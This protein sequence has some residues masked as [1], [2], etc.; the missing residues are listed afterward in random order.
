MLSGTAAL[1]QAGGGEAVSAL[2]SE[3][4]ALDRNRDGLISKVEALG[5]S[6]IQ[7]RF[8]VFDRDKDGL[9]SDAEY[10]RAVEDNNR[11][12]LHDSTIT[13]RVKAAL[14]AAR[15]IPSLQI[16]VETYEGRVQLTGFV[17]APDIASRAGR[18]TAAVSGVRT[19]HNDIAVK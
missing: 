15:G 8:S 14:L 4:T 6:E 11:R 13:A 3:F 9:L 18:V 17:G 2:R 12:I 5:N 19:V 16:A 7:K 10:V 1:A